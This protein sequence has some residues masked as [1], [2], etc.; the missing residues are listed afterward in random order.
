MFSY[1]YL[2]NSGFLIYKDMIHPYPPLLTM[3]L[4]YLYAF[5]GYSLTALKVFT[6]SLFIFNDVVIYLLVKKITGKF[7]YALIS[8]LFYVLT[9]PFLEGNML[10]YDVASLSPLLTGL[11]FGI[12]YFDKKKTADLFWTGLFLTIAVLIK[13]TAGLYF[14]GLITVLLL[15]KTKVRSIINLFIGPLILGVPLLVRLIQEKAL[16]DFV[17]W[18][19]YYPFTFWTKFPGYVR[20]DISRNS[21]LTLLILF[22][23]VF[24]LILFNLKRLFKDKNILL[25]LIFFLFGL[26]C[27]YPRFSFFHFQP[28]LGFL[29]VL[30]GITLFKLKLK[31]SLVVIGSLVYLLFLLMIVKPV[32]VRDWGEEP[33]FMGKVDLENAKIISDIV[34]E[35]KVYLLGLNSSLYTLSETLPP[36]RWFDNYGWYLEVPGVQEEILGRW[37]LDL[38]KYIFWKNPDTGPS[39]EI[40]VYQPAKIASFIKA[41]YNMKG[42]PMEGVALWVL[43]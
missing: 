40:G 34:K 25:P 33:R 29:S 41:N 37:Q 32:I 10:W 31:K 7:G 23:P 13:Q 20:M 24:V 42:K 18:V 2:R 5:F 4:S 21:I 30:I 19:F 28:A 12:S 27:V 26:V 17:N 3:A 11:Y 16:G 36:K 35:N 39:Y 8:L 22:I 38:P 6:W 43:K 14:V 9:Q 15:N 1:S